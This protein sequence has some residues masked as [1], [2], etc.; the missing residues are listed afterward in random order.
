M[1]YFSERMEG[2]DSPSEIEE[3]Q[4]YYDYWKGIKKYWQSQTTNP[5]IA[6]AI[7]KLEKASI[8]KTLYTLGTF[9]LPAEYNL[10]KEAEALS[11]DKLAELTA[12][13]QEMEKKQA[14]MQVAI[15]NLQTALSEFSERLTANEQLDA[16]QQQQID[17]IWEFLKS[18]FPDKFPDSTDE[19]PDS[20]FDEFPE[21]RF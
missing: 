8:S 10:W 5:T 9:V 13:Q 12:K 2:V 20:R 3:L 16:E 4:E 1:E 18:Q 11:Y 21:S 7:Y 17:V 19:S 6:L 14:E 15:A